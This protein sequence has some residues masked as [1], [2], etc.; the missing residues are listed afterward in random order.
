AL[1]DAAGRLAHSASLGPRLERGDALVDARNPIAGVG[2][3]NPR[4]PRLELLQPLL[5]PRDAIAHGAWNS[6]VSRW[7]RRSGRRLRHRLDDLDAAPA[8]GFDGE[9]R[10]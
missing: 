5:E 9:R 7:R 3:R 10:A 4:D 6:L 8:V 2:G 1:Q